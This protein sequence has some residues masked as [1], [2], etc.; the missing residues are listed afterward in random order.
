MKVKDIVKTAR[1]NRS[2]KEFANYICKSQGLLSK[3]ELGLVNPP[4]N[5]IN[6]C[7]RILNTKTTSSSRLAERIKSELKSDEYEFA[8]R[9]IETILD[10]IHLQK[11]K[12]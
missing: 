2:Q 12:K 8:R 7:L 6:K 11:Y 5:V 10:S 3:Y 4:A 9:A 1:G